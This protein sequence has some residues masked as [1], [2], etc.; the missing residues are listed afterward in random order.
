MMDAD[1]TKYMYSGLIHYHL[2]DDNSL[3]CI[4]FLGMLIDNTFTW[5][6]QINYVYHGLSQVIYLLKKLV[7]HAP[8]GYT[9]LDLYPLQT[10]DIL[11]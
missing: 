4:K 7:S 9:V 1:K 11:S 10:D 2:V 8:H 5:N 3:A 6:H